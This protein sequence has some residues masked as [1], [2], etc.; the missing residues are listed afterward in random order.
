MNTV[1]HRLLPESVSGLSHVRGQLLKVSL[2]LM[3]VG[4]VAG[5]SLWAT[6]GGQIQG[7]S[8]MQ[9]RMWYLGLAAITAFA[10]S[11]ALVRWWRYEAGAICGITVAAFISWLITRVQVTR[12]RRLLLVSIPLPFLRL[13]CHR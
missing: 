5:L 11:Y 8:V 2:A 1:L 7:L 13:S 10:C 12:G 4:L 9:P 6:L 3:S